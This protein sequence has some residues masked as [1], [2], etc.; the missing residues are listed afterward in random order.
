[1]NSPFEAAADITESMTIAIDQLLT[2]AA[3][4]AQLSDAEWSAYCQQAAAAEVVPLDL[5]SSLAELDSLAEQ[6]L[7][8]A[9]PGR[10]RLT[11]DDFWSLVLE[12]LWRG[13][14]AQD[15]AENLPPEAVEHVARLYRRLGPSSRAR[16]QLLHLLAGSGQRRA[17]ETFSELMVS[18]PPGDSHEV[19]LSFVP[20]FQHKTYPPESLFPRLL[21]ALHDATLA[22]VVLDLANYLTRSRRLA[23]HPASGR[24]D[25]LSSL[26]SGVVM[27]LARLEERPDEFAQ[28]PAEL[29]Q[30]V[31]D[32]TGLVVA[33]TNALALIGDRRVTGKLHQTLELSHRRIRTEAASALATLGDERGTEVLVEMAAEPVV[34]LRALSTLDALDQLEKVPEEH[35]SAEARAEAELAVRLALPTYFGTPPK[36][37]ALVD[38]CRRHWPGYAEAVD[39]YLFRYEYDFGGR[40]LEGIGIAGPVVHAFRA[41]LADLAPSDIYAAYAGWATEHEEIREQSAESLTDRER[42]EWTE[43]RGA[44]VG[45]GYHD[46]QLVKVGQFFGQ[47][48]S[49]AASRHHGQPGILV[50]DG[51]KVEWF[52]STG[53]ARSVGA[54]EAYFIVKGRKLLRGSLE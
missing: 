40:P 42:S 24:V 13:V 5:P 22:T 32:S 48:H 11:A 52:S 46:P 28:S 18:D 8:E 3:A 10:E 35:R 19:L 16:H 27:R 30:I 29:N 9:S 44:L 36:R 43:R 17:L 31:S 25:R 38:S 50:D 21:D 12:K 23:R 49:I 20:L 37:L 15:L 7:S 47:R 53:A 39:C 14:T 45:M 51:R 33:L 54:D 26:L 34:R 1:M 4:S 6:A 2:S 41:D